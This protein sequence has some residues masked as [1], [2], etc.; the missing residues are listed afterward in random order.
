MAD[1]KI[2]EM[3]DASTLNGTEVLPGV[4]TGANVK[5]TL[6]NVADF[7]LA[8]KSDQT[9]AETASDSTLG[10][11]NDTKWFTARSF[12]W[13]WDEMLTVANTITGVWAAPKAAL[14]TNTAQI[15]TCDFVQDEIGKVVTDNISGAVSIDL[16]TGRIF[17]LTV[18]AD[19]TSF[20]F[21]NAVVGK[22]Y[23]FVFIKLTTNKA[24]PES[25]WTA[26][27][28]YF[29]FGNKPVLSDPTTNG[30]SPAKSK[31]IITAMCSEAGYLDII[32]TPDL[33][34]N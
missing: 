11:R 5:M 33:I 10:N 26:D 30:S 13:A 18:T 8:N 29:P 3:T 20:T 23:V 21:T 14:G 25:A 15:A 32:Q 9:T 4:Q 34:K 22:T 16:S 31:D 6:Q 7:V 17:I 27:K 1:Q 12:R 24:F 19:V 28:F 2:S